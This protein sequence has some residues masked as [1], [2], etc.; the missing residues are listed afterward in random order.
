LVQWW[1]RMFP[2]TGLMKFSSQPITEDMR[3][4]MIALVQLRLKQGR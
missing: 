1:R 4:D 2:R 3:P